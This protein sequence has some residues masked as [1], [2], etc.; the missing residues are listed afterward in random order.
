MRQAVDALGASALRRREHRCSRADR[1]DSMRNVEFG[2]R[3]RGRV[4]RRGRLADA[5]AAARPRGR[6]PVGRGRTMAVVRR[7]R[8]PGGRQAVV[9]GTVRPP[10]TRER[11]LR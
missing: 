7:Y 8:H 11:A 4:R 9:M 3:L 1:P 10:V 6:L 2:P 5:E